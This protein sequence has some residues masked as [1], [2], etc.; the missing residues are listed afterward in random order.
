MLSNEP[1]TLQ[2]QW[3]Y[4]NTISSPYLNV[5]AF[6]WSFD[7]PLCNFWGTDELLLFWCL[8]DL[9]RFFSGSLSRSPWSPVGGFLVTTMAGGLS[10][11]W[12]PLSLKTKGKFVTLQINVH[13]LHLCITA[14]VVLQNISGGFQLSLV[15]SNRSSGYRPSL[16]RERSWFNSGRGYGVGQVVWSLSLAVPRC[17]NSISELEENRFACVCQSSM[18][19]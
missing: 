17:K 10:P 9:A 7:F 18:G 1:K 12:L 11:L 3:T 14:M 4:P 5:E 15:A 2:I 6:S 16:V 19:M 13:V 8:S